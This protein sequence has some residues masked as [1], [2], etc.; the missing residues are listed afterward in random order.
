M[1]DYHPPKSQFRIFGR[2]A[3]EFAILFSIYTLI[4]ILFFHA[5]LPG[6]KSSLIGPPEDSLMEYWDSWYFT[7]SKSQ[8]RFFFTNLIQFPEGTSLYYQNFGH[9]EIFLISIAERLFG[10][11]PHTLVLLQNLAILLSFP[12][13]GVGAFYVVRHFVGSTVGALVGGFVFAF[14]PSHVAHM[15]HHLDLSSIELIPFFV[16]CYLRALQ[17]QS[18][19]WLAA[20]GLF[21]VL[22]ALTHW[23]YLF[24]SAYFILFETAYRSIRDRAL[25]RGWALVAPVACLAATGLVLSPI[26]IPMAKLALGGLAV[27]A[28]IGSCAADIAAYLAAPP[29]HLLSRLTAGIYWRLN[30]NDWEDTVYLGLV[31]VAIAGWAIFVA[32]GADRP[33][34]RYA[35]C[36]M[37]VFCI[38]A[39][40]DYLHVLGHDTIPMP[41]LLWSRLPFFH[42]VRTTSRAIVVAYLFL[43]IIVGHAMALL[44]RE[45]QRAVRWAAVAA[46]ALIML[47]FYPAHGLVMAP[48][49]CSPGFAI[50]RDDPEP[51]FGVF[52]LP[53]GKPAAYTEGEIDMLQQAACHGRP[54][55]QGTIAR[56]VAVT[57]RDR[58]ETHDF[59]AQKKQLIDAGV[60]YIVIHK[61]IGKAFGWRPE[62]GEQDSYRRTYATLYEDA[63]LTILR[64]YQATRAVK[65]GE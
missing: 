19:R 5:F 39:S 6:L 14:N 23:Y 18:W 41:A 58:L 53:S 33:L 31:N 28:D 43:A 17:R 62:D 36:G 59:A 8:A 37:A 50:I 61:P 46:T 54:I 63:E 30:G 42:N 2:Q 13:A 20:A 45:R 1:A 3:A 16:I 11:A 47:D 10:S 34:L 65:A 4:A 44:W 26:M 22:N 29:T 64:V 7:A 48:V 52:N 51:G 9:P 21:F 35:L 15:T 27:S 24:Y 56:Q 25:P 12:L 38:I 57:L 55:A 49:A 60:K 40:G 32:R